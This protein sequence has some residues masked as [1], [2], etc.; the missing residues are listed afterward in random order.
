M[1]QKTPD[2]LTLR[3]ARREALQEMEKEIP[4]LAAE[5]TALRRW[6]NQGHDPG[7]NPWGYLDEDAWPMNY[8]EAYRRHRG[9]YFNVYYHVIEE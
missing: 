9:Y 3:E 7:D 2:S 1:K 8:I 4:M 6:V 5:R